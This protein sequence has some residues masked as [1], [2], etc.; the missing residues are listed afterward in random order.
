M[1][2]K[3]ETPRSWINKKMKVILIGVTVALVV[4]LSAIPLFAIIGL[5]F[6]TVVVNTVFVI[7]ILVETV[8]MLVEGIKIR[9]LIKSLESNSHSN[10]QD[11]LQAITKL[12]IGSSIV[13]IAI[14]IIL[15]ITTL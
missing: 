1:L 11:V 12:V 13:L 4:I 14:M 8:L 9:K 15:V 3:N 10:S 6:I 5:D 7:V 2:Q